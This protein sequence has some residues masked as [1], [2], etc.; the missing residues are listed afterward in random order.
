MLAYPYLAVFGTRTQM[1]TVWPRNM[2]ICTNLPNWKFRHGTN[3]LAGMTAMHSA[4][5]SPRFSQ[6]T[7]VENSLHH[8]HAGLDN[9]P[10]ISF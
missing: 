3:M 2:T 10:L 5:L 8:V 1:P 4:H 7:L 6:D 9:Y